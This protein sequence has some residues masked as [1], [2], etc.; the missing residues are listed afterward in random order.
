MTDFDDYRDSYPSVRM[1]RE[2]GILELTLN[3][4]GGSLVWGAATRTHYDLAGAFNDVSRDIENRVVVMTG[5]GDVHSGP[6]ADDADY[7]MLDLER[8]DAMR[9]NSMQCL[10]SLL[11]IEAPVISCIN[12]PVYRHAELALLGDIVLA[13]D[14][15]TVQ[16]SA[17]F[18]RGQVPGDGSHIVF[19]YLL[20]PRRASYFML[21]GQELDAGEL[22]ELGLV[23]EVMAAE[24]LLPRA[25][26]IARELARQNSLT[27]RHTRTLLVQPLR[28]LAAK[29]L[30]YGFALEG[31]GTVLEASLR[32][33]NDTTP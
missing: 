21:T 27:L 14:A 17:H 6:R 3:T 29:W 18:V 1:R 11:A 32:A 4:D 2:D 19:P 16:D 7:P 9:F 8:W 5:T 25:H 31:Q 10:H 28:E 23:N 33:A 20:G 13:A 30:G 15:A 12:G 22:R 26:E 24:E